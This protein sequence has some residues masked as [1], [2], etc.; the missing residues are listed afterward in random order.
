MNCNFF[1]GNRRALDRRVV[2]E[3]RKLV[4]EAEALCVISKINKASKPN[5]TSKN[6]VDKT[7]N[8][9]CNNAPFSLFLYFLHL[10]KITPFFCVEMLE[11]IDLGFCIAI[12]SF[13]KAEPSK[14]PYGSS[15]EV[16]GIFSGFVSFGSQL[17]SKTPAAQQ[18]SSTQTIGIFFPPK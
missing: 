15:K 17:L 6:K 1:V 2:N 4:L 5:D 3:S 18:I 9:W 11:T 7:I 13:Q 8:L 10:T 14:E 12:C 16:L